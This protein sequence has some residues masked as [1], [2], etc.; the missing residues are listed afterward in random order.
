MDGLGKRHEQDPRIISWR[1]CW[2]FEEEHQQQITSTQTEHLGGIF[3]QKDSHDFL[4]SNCFF[5]TWSRFL[6]E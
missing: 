1:Q 4:F 2:L 6:D 3:F 5:S